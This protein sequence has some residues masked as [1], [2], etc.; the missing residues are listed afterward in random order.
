MPPLLAS[1]LYSPSSF[2]SHT[3]TRFLYVN[4]SETGGG[5]DQ[6]AVENAT[7]EKRAEHGQRSHE[8]KLQ[9]M[10]KHFAKIT[11][12]A[13]EKE[14]ENERIEAQVSLPAIWGLFFIS[15]LHYFNI[16]NQLAELE[17]ATHER[18]KIYGVQVARRLGPAAEETDSRLSR[19]LRGRKLADTVNT[20]E[21]HLRMLNT[22]LDTLRKRTFPSFDPPPTT[23]SY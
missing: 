17:S 13:M 20:Q 7:L 22:A 15:S 19:L 18:Q 23:A 1:T 3:S 16:T 8:Q 21:E 14:A 11:K 4:E 5:E 9:E 12:L 2:P 10:K 6:H